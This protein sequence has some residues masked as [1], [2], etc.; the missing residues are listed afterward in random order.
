MKAKAARFYGNNVHPKT[1]QVKEDGAKW[2]LF[3]SNEK[4]SVF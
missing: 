2:F 3:L 4:S 1:R